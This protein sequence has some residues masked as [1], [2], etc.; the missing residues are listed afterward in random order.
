MGDSRKTKAQLIE[1]LT[2]LRGRVEEL[3][4]AQAQREW[5]EATLRQSEARYRRIFENAHDMIYTHDLEGNFTSANPAMIKTYGYTCEEFLRLNISDVVD[6]SY[7]PIARE[8]IE[9]KLR[10]FTYTEPYQLLTRAKDGSGVWVEVGSFLIL[11]DAGYLGVQGILRDI[12]ERKRAEEALRRARDELEIRVQERTAEL[13]AANRELQR[14]IVEH[15]RTEA[16][17]RESERRYRLLAENATDVIWTT[18]LDLRFTYISPSTQR[19]RGYSVRHAM[20]QTL[21]DMLTGE[22]YDVAMKTFLEIPPPAKLRD[23]DLL[24]TWTLELELTCKDGSRVWTE[25]KISFLRDSDGRPVG[26]LGVTRDITERKR[27]EVEKGKLQ[28]QL[29]QAQKMEAVGQ[30]AA[31][32]AHDFSNL[33]AVI[34][35]RAEQ[36][37]KALPADSAALEPLNMIEQ[38]GQQAMEAARSLLAFSRNLPTNKM[39]VNVGSLVDESSRLWRRMLPAAIKLQVETSADPPLWVNADSTQLQQVMLNLILNARDAMPSGGTLLVRVSPAITES[40]KK[41][42]EGPE[43]TDAMARIEVRD[44]GVGMSPD[45]VPRIFEPFFTTKPRGQGTGLGLSIVHGIVEDHGGRVRVQSTP[46]RGSA[47]TILLPSLQTKTLGRSEDAER[48]GALVLLAEAHR[49]LREIMV[50]VLRSRGYDVLQAQDG[51]SAMNCYR[52]NSGRI[53]MLVLDE[54]LPERSGFDCL[55][56]IRSEDNRTP[57]IVISSRSDA[58]LKAQLDPLTI[59]LGKPF[60]VPELGDLVARTLSA[61]ATQGHGS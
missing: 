29:H 25:V 9:K 55:A 60:G 11:E 16:A 33:L 2:S 5:A 39:P 58:E 26:F 41:P 17:L 23:E 18:D 8:N 37:R 20:T 3:T 44:D 1:E 40:P 10:G 21:K 45:I 13:I 4:R 57:A 56:E 27:A 14:E 54:E 30:L 42:P 24:R 15:K 50:S 51:A 46:G 36:A 22:S 35:G 38:V 32:A 43:A 34:L 12:T 7:L 49:L 61:S 48:P 47:F 19:L 31:G 28:E 6:A 59:V 52:E 53:R